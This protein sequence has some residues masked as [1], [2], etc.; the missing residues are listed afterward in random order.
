MLWDFWF[1]LN[2]TEFLFLNAD[3]PTWLNIG[4]TQNWED[5]TI[6]SEGFFLALC[7]PIHSAPGFKKKK[8]WRKLAMLSRPF[9][10]CTSYFITSWTPEIFLVS[11]FSRKA[12]PNPQFAVRVHKFLPRKKGLEIMSS[13]LKADFHYRAPCCLHRFL[14][15]LKTWF[16]NFSTICQ[17]L[18]TALSYHILLNHS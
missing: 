7:V 14:R 9:K 8:L 13:Y 16:C 2:L 3:N 5:F 18:L 1:C 11:L 6:S 10:C 12:N 4:T 17:F 15:P